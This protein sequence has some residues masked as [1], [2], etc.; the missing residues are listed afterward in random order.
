[1]KAILEK[2]RRTGDTSFACL[3]FELERFNCPW[4][5]HPE[6]E[7]TLIVSSCGQRFVGDHIGRFAEGDLVLL[8]PDLPHMY[9]NDARP[10]GE[11]APPACSAPL[12][13]AASIV[14]QFLP[15][16]MGD[17]FMLR[18]EM[19]PIH[20]L[21]ERSR[22]GL[23]FHGR[24]REEAVAQM[25][26]MAAA[27]GFER[28]MRLL[29]ILNLLAAAPPEEAA[30]LASPSFSP[31]LAL[32]QGERINRVCELIA[33]RYRE[34]ITQAEAA[35]AAGMGVTSFSRFFRRATNRTFREFL[36]EV[37]IGHAAQALL[38]SD[39]TVAE[40]CYDCG[41]GNLSNFNRQFLRL[42]SVPPREFRRAAAEA[43]AGTPPNASDARA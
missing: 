21:L 37:R 32:Y 14:V 1:M 13:R 24:T 29:T 18:G 8:G 16:F 26:A 19:R 3:A 39:R 42:R 2:V 20:Q 9:I 38:E 7:L 5:Y 30:P 28:L 35:R 11:G 6:I 34:D 12:P 22:T 10:D 31:A 17:S 23:A 36:N 4:H 15:G 43:A 27:E 25:R 41:Y 40:I 33:R